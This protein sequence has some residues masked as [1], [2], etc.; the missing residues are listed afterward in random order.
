MNEKDAINKCICLKCPSY[1]KCNEKIAYC[2][3]AKSRS[4]CIN[5]EKGCICPACPVQT[6][7]G[8]NHVYYCT[9]GSEKKQK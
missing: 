8:F 4:K 1:L 3:T 6:I 5:I 2:I 7:S 9:R